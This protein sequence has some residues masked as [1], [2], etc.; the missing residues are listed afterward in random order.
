MPQIISE[1]DFEMAQ[2]KLE[3]NIQ[4]SS[5]NT[6]VPSI[7]Q[8]LLTCGHCGGA[9][10][11]KARSGK[12]IYYSCSKRLNG[13]KCCGPSLKQE[14]LDEL[15]WKQVI[16]LLKNPLLIEEEI[17]RRA[18]DNIDAQKIKEKIKELDKQ[19]LRL[20][21]AKD[22]LLDAY[23]DGDCL[24]LE[25][26]KDRLKGVSLKQKAMLKEKKSLG[27]ITESDKKIENLKMHM[28]DL[29]KRLEKSEKLSIIDKQNVLR[30]L[31]GEIVITNDQVEIRHCI[32]SHDPESSSF[33][34]LRS[35]GYS[36]PLG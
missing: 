22:K 21:K 7:L 3:K 36:S 29:Q 17:K 25:S 6:R 31:V 34:P 5:R 35:D 26:L 12:Y 13:G 2:F 24:S 1:S 27:E 11:K 32:P 4:M 8:G 20:D 33:S 16:E 14:D 28:K 19:L 23:Q 15:V 18:C 30:L 10:Y 9:Y